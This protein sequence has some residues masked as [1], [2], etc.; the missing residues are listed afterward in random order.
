MK[1]ACLPILLV[2][3][4]LAIIAPPS[5][6]QSGDTLTPAVRFSH[7]TADNGL[8]ENSVGAILQDQRGFIWIGTQ[9]GLSRFDGYHF[10]TY[11][12]DPDDPT[13][14]SHNYVQALF[15]DKA[16]TLWIATR[17]G[18]VDRFDPQT[19]IFTHYRHDPQ[20]PNSLGGDVI[21]SIFQDSKG[22]FWFGGP[23]LSGLTLFDPQT[24]TF[25]RHIPTG[26][27]K[28]PPPQAGQ[29]QPPRPS[30]S[31]VSNRYQGAG[32]WEMLEDKA[33]LIW[34]ATDD[35]LVQF[36]PRSQQFTHFPAPPAERRLA[37]VHQDSAGQLW[38]AGTSG[39]YLFNP[40]RP[41]HPFTPYLPEPVWINN[42]YEDKDGLFWLATQ[43]DGLYL[44]NP[45]TG[46]LLRRFGHDPADPASLSQN[47][48]MALYQDQGGVLWIGTGNAGL[49]LFN[50]RQNQFAYYRHSPA[51]PG[52]LAPGPVVALAGDAASRLWVAT[53]GILNRVDLAGGQVRRY[54]PP[55]DTKASGQDEIS[56]LYLDRQGIVWLGL[57]RMLYRFDPTTESFTP[58]N[59]RLS[60]DPGPPLQLNAIY[61]DT[62]NNLWLSVANTG[63]YRFDREEQTFKVYQQP[64]LPAM[65]RDDPQNVATN[66]LTVIYGDRA[67]QIWIGYE[68]GN[69]SRLDPATGHFSH[70][71]P[72]EAHLDG[73]EVIY[74]DRAGAVWLASS[75]GLTRFDPAGETFHHYAEK[76]GLP[77]PLVVGLLEDAGGDLWLST[78]R[79][80]VRFNPQAGMF[81]TY[82]VTDGIQGNEFNPRASWQAG[83]G[84]MF[85][86]GNNGLT[87]FYPAEISD[88]TYQP[89][90][91]LTE[92]RLA[93]QPVWPGGAD[94]PLAAPIWA[95]ANLTLSSGQDIISFE[96]AALDYAAPQQIRYRYKLEGLE[97][98]WNEVGSDRRSATYINL[99]PGD[100]LFR[101]Q[102]RSHNGD[103][104]ASEVR[105]PVTITP[106]WWEM[107]WFRAAAMVGLVGLVYGGYRWRVHAIQAR[108]RLL[109]KQVAFRT[110]ELVALTN[111]LTLSSAHNATIAELSRSLIASTSVEAISSLVVEVAKQLTG[112]QVGYAGYVDPQ[113]GQLTF[114]ASPALPTGSQ[115]VLSVPALLG[116]TQVGQI[117]LAEARRSYT[118]QD[119]EL[120]ERLAMIYALA[121]QRR[122]VETALHEAKQ[123][124]EAANRAKSTFLAN[125]SHELR[126]PLNAIL[127][128]AQVMNG[129]QT[130][131]PEHRENVGI[132][133]RSGEHLLSLINQV[134][135]LS[136]IE[137][138]HMSLHEKDFDL[139][140]LLDDLRDMFALKAGHKNLR[141]T[142][143]RSPNLPQFIRADQTKLRQ[144]L[145]N[146][147]NNAI[148]F[149]E[150]GEVSCRVSRPGPEPGQP[151]AVTRLHVEVKDSGPG[152]TPAD[153]NQLFE[154]FTQ[155][156]TGR[157][158]QEGTGLG[159][160]ISRKFVQL[161]GGDLIVQSEVGRGSTFIFEI[162]IQVVAA[163]AV[164]TRI[165]PRRVISLAPGQPPP[166]LLI[167][168]DDPINRQLLLKLLQPL[169]FELREA[170]NGQQALALWES[171][172]PQLIWMDMRMPVMD[173]Y[174]ATRQIKS[175]TRGQ[176]T[177]VIALTASSFE[178]NRALV[179]STGCDDFIR[180]PF[181]ES[182][183][184]EMMAR[185]IGLV[186]VYEAVPAT[187]VSEFSHDVP[188]DVEGL[189]PELLT[190]LIEALELSD[191]ERVNT[192][193]AGI[194]AY[195]PSL[196]G[197][198][199]QLAGDFKYDKILAL[200][201]PRS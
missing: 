159:L 101:V 34:L 81:R 73:I 154:A 22:R 59:L 53:G 124:A 158:A 145:I 41:T 143:E 30:P 88:N 93:N 161:M 105:L 123:A 156:P 20:N 121:L 132:I 15:E 120:V 200:I 63:L 35:A 171:F 118:A 24:N 189:P 32:V 5:Q 184:F 108:N 192:A 197:S 37:V 97:K 188:G 8:A 178:E 80:L 17:G 62:H 153:F 173:G 43:Q 174:E 138:G 175:T 65:V 87:A 163:E 139:Y 64:R 92:L 148:K 11:Q 193:I 168:D 44:F 94:S 72:Q 128:F 135:D 157:Q 125:M 18:G 70:Y 26:P 10:I 1:H 155:T 165:D 166:R 114:P 199:A 25:T 112:S 76:D 151:A 149:T 176:G 38:V 170:E 47:Q 12:H 54:S 144:V 113:T 194:H 96:F 109:E 111:D 84:R 29:G 82:T 36:D 95:T 55:L 68:D 66:K 134:L 9:G 107:G 162:D 172:E 67:G 116:Q 186:Y 77:T 140:H 39:L 13:S 100:Y 129:S 179:L 185:H 71:F 187:T 152:I 201:Q 7:L 79:G 169:G 6:A 3:L 198:L 19:E 181:R 195:N 74:Q 110:Q 119:R 61:E 23:P 45:H 180:K 85:F 40:Q 33:G 69:F 28:T 126:S 42:L 58:Y 190:D 104:S 31:F 99:S 89:P 115:P 102:G 142:Y 56:A 90:V 4:L 130:L 60:P 127:G 191:I 98:T 27:I 131:P 16:G 196:A 52:G 106:P 183:I 146:L 14:L 103:W 91:L 21:F 167:V 75:H 177:A 122:E 141:L 50:P 137:A 51:N 136:K 164:E 78:Q 147:L 150:A 2:L 117:T 49:N 57:H 160:V 182:E 133:S 46:Q 83:D 86:G 48:V